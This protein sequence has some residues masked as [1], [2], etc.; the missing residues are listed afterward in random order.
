MRG[1]SFTAL[2]E[3]TPATSQNQLPRILHSIPSL[4][5]DT[6]ATPLQYNTWQHTR[7][8]AERCEAYR[9]L[10]SLRELQPQNVT[11]TG[12]KPKHGAHCDRP[13]PDRPFMLCQNAYDQMDTRPLRPARPSPD[14]PFKECIRYF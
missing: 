6:T 11:G 12:W 3:G 2:P 4:V 7:E 9:S 14:R 5:T 1:I 10:L 8:S 13:G